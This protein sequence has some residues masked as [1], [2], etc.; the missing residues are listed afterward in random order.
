MVWILFFSGYPLL[1][2]SQL[3]RNIINYNADPRCTLA[4]QWPVDV[5]P[6]C[7]HVVHVTINSTSLIIH[8]HTRWIGLGWV[9]RNWAILIPWPLLV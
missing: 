3:E 6:Y 2:L 9:D 7:C 5:H 8:V 4:V 1:L